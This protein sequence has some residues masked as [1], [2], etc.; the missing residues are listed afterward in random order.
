[1]VVLGLA[2]QGKALARY[3]AQQGAEVVVSDLKP[4]EQLSEAIGELAD[5]RLEYRFG[6]HSEK[7]LEGADLLCL[8][9]GVPADLPLAEQA[10]S[11]GIPISN[12]SQLFLEACPAPVMGITGSAGKSTTTELLGRMA[13]AEA[14]RR[15]VQAWVGGNIGR[16]LLAHVGQIQP[17]DLVVMELS[18]FQLELMTLSPQ[19]A[20]VLNLT[21]NHLDRH[22]TMAAYTEAKA[23][24]LAQQGPGDAAVLNRDDPGA[25]A[26]RER[27]APSFAGTGA[28]LLSFGLRPFEGEGSY[29][30]GGQ[31]RL[32]LAGEEQRLFPVEEIE[33]RG[34]H[35]LSN[36]LAAA[37]MAGAAGMHPASMAAGVQGFTGVEH[38]LELV[39]QH[40]GVQ[41]FNDSIA[42]APERTLAA[43]RSFGEPL[44]LLVGGRDKDLDWSGL[45]ELIRQRVDKLVLFGQIGPMVE[46]LLAEAGPSARPESVRRVQGLDQAVAAAAE[47][48]EPGDVVLL[49]PGG[50]SFDEFADFA[51]RGERFKEL[52]Q[53]L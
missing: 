22:G 17:D 42:T 2:R 4:R 27:V 1:M 41:W 30:D 23:N 34:P 33:L 28:R 39:R 48:A 8:S 10:R 3:F 26:L 6:A 13:G 24:I 5:L 49:S 47:L 7:L 9:G 46:Q 31:V 53:G 35:N 38:R 36:V 32:Q 50:T 18:S 29:I 19:I 44:V 15:G 12:D 21:P 40:A 20:A 11:R 52:V 37:A 14:E 43:I 25:W 16:P 51:A 45:V